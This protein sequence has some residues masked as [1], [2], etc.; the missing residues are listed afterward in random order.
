MYK[1]NPE[2]L[3]ADYEDISGRYYYG[4][5]NVIKILSLES[6][7]DPYMWR[8]V[9][10]KGIN[11]WIH[12]WTIESLYTEIDPALGELRMGV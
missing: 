11:M 8:A 6:E 5:G 10:E 7:G 3:K 9:S 1:K 4:L 12:I 2:H